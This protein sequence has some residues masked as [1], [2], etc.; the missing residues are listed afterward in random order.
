MI[1]LLQ[2]HVSVRDYD[3]RVV[4]DEIKNE[5]LKS[6]QSASTSRVYHL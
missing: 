3:D 6:A 2:N 5:L 4:S 1:E